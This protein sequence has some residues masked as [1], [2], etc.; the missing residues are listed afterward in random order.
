[1]KI[2]TATKRAY[3]PRVHALRRRSRGT[4]GPLGRRF[5]C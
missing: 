2:I 4:F 3:V 5:V 1:V